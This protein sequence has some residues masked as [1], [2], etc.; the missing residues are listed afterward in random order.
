MTDYCDKGEPPDVA[1]CAQR[2]GGELQKIDAFHY[3][4]IMDRCHVIC[5]M[6]DDFL[7]DHP[8]MEKRGNEWCEL[9]QRALT[10]ASNRAAELS[11]KMK[12]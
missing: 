12:I 10:S 3:H 7:I 1:S 9:A 4:E 6:I 2:S 8:A 5:S 11:E